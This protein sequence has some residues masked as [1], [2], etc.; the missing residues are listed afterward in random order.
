VNA[1][2]ILWLGIL[3]GAA[4]SSFGQTWVQTSAPSN[5][6]G[7]VAASAN[8]RILAAGVRHG[9]AS[10]SIYTSDDYGLSWLPTSAPAG[11]WIS[12]ASSAD[13]S[14]LIAAS[15]STGIYT[16]TNS[17]AT[18]INNNLPPPSA[19][20]SSVAASADG[21]KLIA[22]A[23]SWIF[24]STNSGLT[25]IS[26]NLPSRSWCS[27][28]SSADG[29]KL[30]IVGYQLWH[31]TNAGQTWL[32]A[33][34]GLEFMGALTVPSRVV[35]CSA[36]GMKVFLADQD[37][38]GHPVAICVS[39]DAGETWTQ[40]A[41]PTN[42]WAYT[43]ASADAK[44]LVASRHTPI[45]SPLFLSLDGG[46]TWTSSITNPPFT[47]WGQPAVSA[48]GFELLTPI[49]GGGIYMTRTMPSPHIAITRT[50][51]MALSW[52]IPSTNFVLQSSADL[53]TWID[54]TNPPVLNLTNL[55]DE[56]VLPMVDDLDFFRLHTP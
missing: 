48:D 3:S 52:L 15:A 26:N 18:W 7:C 34:Q 54:M 12:I 10:T 36:N 45:D 19:V 17:G 46:A 42:V 33:T 4:M 31:S 39:T 13:G 38:F 29:N 2:K 14:L 1:K 51:G 27:V 44:V 35:A 22:V 25:W 23:N 37:S 49:D 6:W 40:T 50:N 9:A 5:H 20:Y 53:S 43:A 41:S 21:K 28:A 16:S 56:I 55:Q 47:A 11:D 30:V 32:Q 8:G 24:T